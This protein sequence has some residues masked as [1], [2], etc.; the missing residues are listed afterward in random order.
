MDTAFRHSILKTI[1]YFDTFDF[2]LTVEEI[3]RWTWGYRGQTSLAALHAILENMEMQGDVCSSQSFFYLPNR[4]KLVVRRQQAVPLVK[5]KMRIAKKAGKILR[6]VPFVRALFVCNT[7]AGSIPNAESDVDVFIV[8]RPNRLWIARFLI[9]VILSLCRM[10]RTKKKVHNRICLSFYVTSHHLNLADIRWDDQDIYLIY[11]IDQLIPVFDPGQVHAMLHEQNKWIRE[12]LS[13]AHVASIT[14]PQWRVADTVLSRFMRVCAEWF[15]GG[16]F[17]D[18]LEHVMRRMQ[19][20][21]MDKNVQSLQG[22][23]D[24]RVIVNDTMLKFHEN[25]RRERYRNR[26]RDRCWEINVV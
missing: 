13:N 18:R 12:H 24:S 20:K 23:P 21:K 2:P 15:F 1:A 11:W 14:H 3:Y 10:R 25:D 8:I 4:H 9:T 26:W 22:L 6:Y 19:K 7:V 16:I 5:E 17:G